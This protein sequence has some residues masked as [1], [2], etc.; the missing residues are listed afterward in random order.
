MQNRLRILRSLGLGIWCSLPA[1]S[2]AD[3][4]Y[5][6]TFPVISRNSYHISAFH[7][8]CAIRRNTEQNRK[9]VRTFHILVQTILWHSN[10]IYTRPHSDC[11]QWFSF[12]LTSQPFRYLDFTGRR[13]LPKRPFTVS[14]KVL[15][16]LAKQFCLSRSY[17]ENSISMSTQTFKTSIISY[18][19]C[20]QR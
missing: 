11:E 19:H 9:A 16:Q 3:R 7:R 8:D 10:E 13:C 17:L 1:D 14:S 18:Q 12:F 2:P 4:L 15:S 5:L 20:G 6:A